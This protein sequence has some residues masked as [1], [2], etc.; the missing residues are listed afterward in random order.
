MSV[1]IL[2]FCA[3][4]FPINYFKVHFNRICRFILLVS[5]KIA[6]YFY[7]YTYYYFYAM[8]PI[9]LIADLEGT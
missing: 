4:L 8:E 1:L 6:Q 5:F 3:L 7:I 2:E 9:F